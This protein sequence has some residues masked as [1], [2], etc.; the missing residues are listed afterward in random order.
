MRWMIDCAG[1][2][3]A[4]EKRERQTKIRFGDR[5]VHYPFEN[6]LGDLPAQANFECLKGYVHAWQK[7]Q[8]ERSPAPNEFG[9]WVR[10]RFGDGIAEHFMDPYNKKVWKREMHELSSDW[11]A[12]R[13]PDAP[14]EDVLKSSVGIRTEGYTHQASFYYPRSGGF[15]AITDGI[16]STL[17]DRVRLNTFVREVRKKGDGFQVNGED[18]DAVV[19]TLPL[20]DLPKIVVGMPAPVAKAMEGLE[21]N[22]IV[23]LLVALDRAEQPPLSWI[24][25]PHDEQGPTNRVTYMSNYATANA[26]SGKSSFLCEVTFRGGSRAPGTELEGQVVT[27]L[28][29]AGLLKRGEVLFTDRTVSRHAYVV[30]DH[31]YGARREAALVWLDEQGIVPLGRFGRFE[32]DNSDQCVIKARATAERMLAQAQRGSPRP[33]ASDR[34]R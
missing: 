29:R 20:T 17:L 27:G 19:N 24:Y 10:W 9:A 33:T 18:F 5:W 15:Q 32:Y 30:F 23:C 25:L 12:G 11:V 28:E 8:A 1:G 2:E 26:P 34:P 7:R 13:V 21:Y 22:S 14:I 4:F 6:G 31:A 16:A 3:R